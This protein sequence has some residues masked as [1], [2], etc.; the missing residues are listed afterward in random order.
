MKKLIKVFV[1]LIAVLALS[2]C[3]GGISYKMKVKKGDIR[4]TETDEYVLTEV[5]TGIN[6]FGCPLWEKVSI[7]N[8]NTSIDYD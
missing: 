6:G 5:C 1:L 2:S 3:S 8:K 4:T 7:Q